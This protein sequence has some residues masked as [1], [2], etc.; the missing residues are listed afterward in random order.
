M[1]GGGMKY[2]T[3][4]MRRL[5]TAKGLR[6]DTIAEALGITRSGYSKKE[7]GVVPVTIAELATLA[8]FYKVSLA[9][10]F[11]DAPFTD[12]PL[13][14]QAAVDQD[15]LSWLQEQNE[16]LKSQ[17]EAERKEVQ[18]LRAELSTYRKETLELKKALAEYKSRLEAALAALPES[19]AC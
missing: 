3:D 15:R 9:E 7:T 12:K 14:E 5:R 1:G 13:L 6:Q 10:F 11:T 18:E 17:L 8:K 16:W 2:D 4:A 19:K